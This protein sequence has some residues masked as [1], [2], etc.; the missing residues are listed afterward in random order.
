MPDQ[1]Y[2]MT[3]FFMFLVLLFPLCWASGYVAFGSYVSL[4]N[5]P[6]S[7]EKTDVIVTLTGDNNRLREALQ[8]FSNGKADRVFIT[9]ANDSS[10]YRKI[11]SG[12]GFDVKDSKFACCVDIGY[13]AINTQGNA[14]ETSLWL[15]ESGVN[16]KSIRLVT[17]D[18]HILRAWLEFLILPDSIKLTLHPVKSERLK[19]MPF[20]FTDNLVFHEYNKL[21][22]TALKTLITPQPFQISMSEDQ[23]PRQ[24]LVR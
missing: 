21:L 18:Y 8:L 12:N 16:V 14:L 11:I 4:V 7:I 20:I 5:T 19:K 2:P 17:S 15:S 3:R 23:T 9:G 13:Y 1:S 6:T 24:Q 10:S 22:V